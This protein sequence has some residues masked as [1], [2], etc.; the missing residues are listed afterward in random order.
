MSG[1]LILGARGLGRV[2]ADAARLSG[3]WPE[4]AFLDDRYP[5]I[6][7]VDGL[8]VLGGV[9]AA[10]ELRLRFV[11][12]VVAVEDSRLRLRTLQ[13]VHQEGLHLVVVAHPTAAVSDRALFGPG[14]VIMAQCAINPGARLGTGCIVNTGATVDHDCDLGPGVHL[15]PGAHLGGNV[16]IRERSWLGT[17]ASVRAGITIGA[18]VTVGDGA[19]VITDL[20]DGVTAVGVPARVIRETALSPAPKPAETPE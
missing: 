4:I 12:A 2:V 17:G 10:A 16:T 7:A 1:L 20:P 5:D 14:T 11:D 8:P 18:D 3:R 19:A 13:V 6:Q 15:S 9:G